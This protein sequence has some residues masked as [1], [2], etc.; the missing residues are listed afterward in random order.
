MADDHHHR[1]RTRPGRD[2]RGHAV[3]RRG[4]PERRDLLRRGRTRP[5]PAVR[6]SAAPVHP[7]QPA[8]RAGRFRRAGGLRPH[9]VILRPTAPPTPKATRSSSSGASA[10]GRASRRRTPPTPTP[11]TGA[12]PR[13]WRCAIPARSSAAARRRPSA[14]S[15]RSR[16]SR[17]PRSG[18]WS[19]RARRP[20]S[21]ARPRRR[22]SG[23]SRRTAGISA[24]APR[25]S[26]ARQC[27]T[28][29]PRRAPTPSPT[30]SP[31]TPAMPATPP[32]RPSRSSSTP[33]RSRP[34]ATT[35]ASRSARK[36][37]STPRTP[38]DSDGTLVTF[39]WDFGDGTT[40][41]GE[42]V[43]H[44]YAA[45]GTYTVGLTVSDDSAVANSSAER[46]PHHHRQRPA[47]ARGR[48]GQVRRDRPDH[49]LRCRRLP[50]Q[51]RAAHRPRVGFRRRQ[52]GERA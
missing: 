50:R 49:H 29:L 18:S 25:Q 34:R 21:T 12:T 15:S 42:L 35:A 38:T 48:R 20:S 6:A 22:A 37:C 19:A 3:R 10:T 24:T 1:A 43:R 31:T 41:D 11:R 39:V 45:P 8:D 23:G 33:S 7:E 36:P 30:P 16:R 17:C 5:P 13:R 26:K 47:G 52:H 9:G 4:I 46:F 32:R 28:P 14:S 40:G 2:R 44:A 27:A 51:R